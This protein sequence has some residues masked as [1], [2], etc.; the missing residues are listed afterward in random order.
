M[1]SGVCLNSNTQQY[2]LLYPYFLDYRCY[3][4]ETKEQHSLSTVHCH[5]SLF[6]ISLWPHFPASPS[7]NFP[8]QLPPVS[9]AMIHNLVPLS[10][11]LHTHSLLLAN[12]ALSLTLPL[13]VSPSRGPPPSFLS[14]P[15]AVSVC[16]QR[17][18]IS[19]SGFWKYQ[20][21]SVFFFLSSS[22]SLRH[23]FPLSIWREVWDEV[24]RGGRY[25]RKECYMKIW[26]WYFHHLVSVLC[27]LGSGRN[28]LPEWQI[29]LNSV[30]MVTVSTLRLCTKI[31]FNGVLAH[32][33]ERIDDWLANRELRNV[34]MDVT[35]GVPPGLMLGPR[36]FTIYI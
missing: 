13:T 29:I 31:K 28:V 14:V 4:S 30:T 19:Q 32:V 2:I 33:L 35:S 11:C 26:G 10:C 25:V 20:G 3:P 18:D 12:L 23:I 8:L 5:H 21:L 9:L 22:P 27:C 7:R 1:Y 34:W 36:Y 24:V 17:G 16:F 6:P 15:H